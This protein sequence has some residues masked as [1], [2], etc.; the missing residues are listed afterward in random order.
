M[1]ETP[2]RFNSI[3]GA[4]LQTQKPPKFPAKVDP[5]RIHDRPERREFVYYMQ[6]IDHDTQ[7]LVGHLSDI[8]RGGF[9]LDCQNPVPINKDFHFT[10]KLTSDLSSKPCMTFTACSKWCK[11]DPLDP[12]IYNAGFQLARVSPEDLEI[13]TLMVEKY[14]RLREKRNI[15]LR[16]SNKW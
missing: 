5:K 8:S 12:N 1:K 10:L 16:R 7:R 15:D 13:F 2:L 14:G 4:L 3:F 9:K 6:V 11:V